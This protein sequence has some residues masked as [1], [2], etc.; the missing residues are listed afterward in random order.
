MRV[1]RRK[2]RLRS[3][4]RWTVAATIALALVVAASAVAGIA[5]ASVLSSVADDLPTLDI[6]A[7]QPLYENTYIY[8]G[9][10][11]PR[12]L[13][14]LRGDGEPRGRRLG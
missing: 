7:Q 3:R 13:A 5:V 1:R 10:K 12:L 14:V 8:D 2:A 9:S 4:D 11:K 6:T